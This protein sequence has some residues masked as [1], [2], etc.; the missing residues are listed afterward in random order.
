MPER[1][2]VE[3]VS[4][5]LEVVV[6]TN[7]VV[8]AATASR[9]GTS[10]RRAIDAYL[11][12]GAN[13]VVAELGRP[14]E[15]VPP[16]ER[17][18]EVALHLIGENGDLSDGSRLVGF[19]YSENECPLGSD[20]R[21]VLSHAFVCRRA[22]EPPWKRGRA[23]EA[24]EATRLLHG[25]LFELSRVLEDRKVEPLLALLE[26][27]VRDQSEASEIPRDVVESDLLAPVLE[28]LD[29]PGGRVVHY[30]DQLVV[31][32]ADEGRLLLPRRADRGP[33]LEVRCDEIS[34]PLF[35][36]YASI[37]DRAQVVRW[38]A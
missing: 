29:R 20:L 9:G 22:S 34:L 18:A 2:A 4:R 13:R 30:L 17:H 27:H 7:Q 3:V 10:V 1:F 11:A 16:E 31:D 28:V 32:V 8:V 35:P 38:S 6:R 24:L 5:G 26:H 37:D 25:A 23:L 36:A 15:D 21:V 12:E 33:V 19:T 14:T